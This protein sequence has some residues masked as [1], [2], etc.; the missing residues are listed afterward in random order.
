[1]HFLL[2]R[3]LFISGVA[4]AFICNKHHQSS[5]NV[6]KGL[7]SGVRP[8]VRLE[9][10]GPGIR[11]SANLAQIWPD[12]VVLAQGQLAPE[13]GPRGRGRRG[14]SLAKPIE[15]VVMVV[16]VVQVRRRRR[17]VVLLGVVVVVVRVGVGRR[18]HSRS[19]AIGRRLVNPLVLLQARVLGGGTQQRLHAPRRRRRRVVLAALVPVTMEPI[20]FFFFF[21]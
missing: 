17:R 10:A 8:E 5:K 20:F 3:E 9:G 13:R 18:S 16:V 14:S 21:R 6:P 1:M 2:H 19:E 7:L 12:L 11:L 4:I 15:L